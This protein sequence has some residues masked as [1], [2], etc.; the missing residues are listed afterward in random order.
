M[1]EIVTLSRLLYQVF[2]PRGCR[3]GGPSLRQLCGLSLD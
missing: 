1:S 3:H 2:R